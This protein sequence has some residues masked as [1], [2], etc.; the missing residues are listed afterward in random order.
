MIQQKKVP[1]QSWPYVPSTGT[2][3]DYWQLDRYNQPKLLRAE[4]RDKKRSGPTRA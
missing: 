2:Q 1:G 3:I 4:G